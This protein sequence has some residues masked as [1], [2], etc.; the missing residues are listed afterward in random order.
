MATTLDTIN[1]DVAK[2]RSYVSL[3]AKQYD[4]LSRKYR[5][6]I[7]NNGVPITLT[8]QENVLMRMQADGEST[9]YVEKWLSW[10]DNNIVVEM[11][12][13]MLSKVGLVYFDFVIYESPTGVAV[14][15]TRLC[16]LTIQ[17]SLIDYNGIIASEDFDIL[18]N[19]ITQAL[20]LP[21]LIADINTTKEQV[22]DLVIS[23]NTQ[24]T[25]F[26]TEFNN[27]S[28]DVQDLMTAVTA[29]MSNIENAAATSA[30][31]SESWAIGGTG[32]R[33]GED[34]DNSEY[35]SQIS[36]NEADRAKIEADRASFYADIII[37]VFSIN[38]ITGHLTYSESSSFVFT[39]N[40]TDGH[41]YYAIQ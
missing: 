8:G 7:T 12:S 2:D 26:Q 25:T 29:Y 14:L 17:E 3:L 40:H 5:I 13:N 9:P 15:S 39:A 37:P 10:E 38:F 23:V 6:N 31:L 4:H 32:T 22:D 33:A 16:R 1:A 35:F 20:T 34:S 27:M 11:T 18:S 28:H 24:M 41:L 36:K 19:L 30:K 21:A